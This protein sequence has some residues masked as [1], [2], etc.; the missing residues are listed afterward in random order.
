METIAGFSI[1]AIVVALVELAKR[2]GLPDRLSPLVAL[3]FGIGFS[4]L[5][6]GISIDSGVA[7]LVVGLSA[8]GLWSGVKSL[9][10]K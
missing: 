4:F 3:G 6:S 5:S 9:A 1:I 7:G 8:C 10:G 2:L